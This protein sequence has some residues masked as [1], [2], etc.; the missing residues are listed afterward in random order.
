M[1]ALNRVA[2]VAGFRYLDGPFGQSSDGIFRSAANV[3][4]LSIPSPIRWERVAGGRVR[5]EL[6][7]VREVVAAKT[8]LDSHER[9]EYDGSE[10]S[11]LYEPDIQ[12][13]VG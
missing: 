2:A 7:W 3:K 11:L 8:N 10:R 9:Q 1:G 4:V 6:G 13:I 5:N 12:T